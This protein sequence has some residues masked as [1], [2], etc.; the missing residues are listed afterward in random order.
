VSS[1]KPPSTVTGFV[2]EL[3]E[4]EI[5]QTPEDER[6]AALL[7]LIRPLE[8]LPITDEAAELALQYIAGGVFPEKYV[9]D[10]RH[11]AV[12]TVHGIRLLASWN[13]R[14][15]VKVATQDRVNYINATLGYS[16]LEIVSPE[17]L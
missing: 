1:G 17:E 2:S 7:E 16:A 3:S 14:H 12:A 10:A 4:L 5:E 8:F 13:F 9:S 6:R 11:L 15:M